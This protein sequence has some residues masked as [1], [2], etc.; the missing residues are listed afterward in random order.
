M[1]IFETLSEEQKAVVY[2]KEGLCAIRAGPGS[3]KT[4]CVSARFIRKLQ[5]W[6][7]KYSGIAVISFTNVAW[8]EIEN[9]ISEYFG[10]GV[11]SPHYLGTIDSFI[12]NF[13]VIPFGHLIMGCSKSPKFVGAPYSSWSWTLGAGWEN[14]KLDFAAFSLNMDDKIYPVEKNWFEFDEKFFEKQNSGHIQNLRKVKEF[15]WK[16]GYVTQA[17]AN[18]IAWKI[19]TS[20]PEITKALVLRFPELII[21]EAQDTSEIQMEILDLLINTGNLQN[22]MLIGD[23]DQSIFEWNDAKPSLFLKKFEEWSENSCILSN[24][25]RSTQKICEFTHPL[26][27]LEKISTSTAKRLE[28]MSEIEPEIIG[29][30]NNDYK[31]ISQKFIEE[32]KATDFISLDSSVIL[33]R[34]KNLINQISGEGESNSYNTGKEGKYFQRDLDT[35]LKDLVYGKYLYDNDNIFEAYRYALM[36]YIKDIENISVCS[37]QDIRNYFEK[38]NYTSTLTIITEILQNLPETNMNFNE[39]ID[40]A[41]PITKKYGMRIKY[42]NIKSDEIH[43][44]SIVTTNPISKVFPLPQAQYKYDGVELSTI[45][46]A[47]GKSFDAVL[48]ILKERTV[49]KKKYSTMLKNMKNEDTDKREK[50]VRE[51]ELRNIYVAITRPKYFLKIAVPKCDLAIWKEY[52]MNI[53]PDN[54]SSLDSFF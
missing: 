51:E 31:K 36:A 14:Y 41:E 9:N 23:P 11:K 2:E 18:Y 1:T 46:K 16:E 47:K 34:S 4:Y 10:H 7:E 49:R 21:D 15:F 45:H 26:S 30:D 44:Y 35:K 5:N 39:W 3:G 13:I 25:R 22:L 32:C 28:K 54:Q 6:T 48:L 43:Q 19:L 53:L 37:H 42:S 38:N 8:K 52:L 20:Y 12:N 33:C 24:N 27:T 17:D 29:Y 50:C 40:K